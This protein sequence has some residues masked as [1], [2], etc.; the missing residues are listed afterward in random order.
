MVDLTNTSF[1]WLRLQVAAGYLILLASPFLLLG[2]VL[3]G[4]LIYG[5]LV[6]VF[7]ANSSIQEN[8]STVRLEFFRVNDLFNDGLQKSGRYLT[9]TSP[10]GRIAYQMP[11]WDWAHRARTSLY[12]TGSKDIAILGPDGEDILIDVDRSKISRAVRI[13]SG[14]WTYLGAFD[15]VQP[16]IG[17][18]VRSLRFIPAL[19]QDECV[20]DALPMQGKPRA[21]A[22]KELCP[23]L[24]S[25]D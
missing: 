22:R 7:A 4:W 12:L 13:S 24:E 6:P 23:I 5:A 21:D 10:H 9:I 25:K 1:T 18:H 20:L 16:V 2:A 17:G 15:F 3:V 14:D 19:E 8:D 11:G